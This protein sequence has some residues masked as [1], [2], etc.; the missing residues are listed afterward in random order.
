M[1]SR[2][3][4]VETATGNGVP[5]IPVQSSFAIPT[6]TPF[7]LTAV[8]VTDPNGDTV[9]YCWE[10]RALGATAA[11]GATDNGASPIVRSRNPSTNPIRTV[12]Q[13][14]NLLNNTFA[15]GRASADGRAGE[16]ALAPDGA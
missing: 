12:P 10:E 11:V 13:L 4:D 14:S 15:T 7:N 9:T 8:G 5:S 3:C 16:L 6:G 2:T 1:N